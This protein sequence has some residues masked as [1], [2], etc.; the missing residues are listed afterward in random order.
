MG[1]T[2]PPAINTLGAP[3]LLAAVIAE[4]VAGDIL[5]LLTYASTNTLPSKEAHFRSIENIFI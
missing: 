5:S 2:L 3:I 4:N 1:F